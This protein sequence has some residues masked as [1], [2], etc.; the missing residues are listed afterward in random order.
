WKWVR[1]QDIIKVK[2]GDFVRSK[3]LSEEGEYLA[4][5]GN[6][7][8][9]YYNKYNVENETLVI[10]RVGAKCGNVHKVIGKSWISDNAFIVTFLVNQDLNY[11]Y[12]LLRYLN[13]GRYASSSAQPVISGKN[14][15]PTPVP[16]PPLKEQKRIIRRLEQEFE[17]E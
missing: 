11:W 15:Y 17:K 14:I 4:Y 5:G 7:V 2:S 1:I 6:G 8:N 16:V 13:L 10:G 9:G 12:H 3:D